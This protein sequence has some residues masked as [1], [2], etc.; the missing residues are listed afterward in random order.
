MLFGGPYRENS[1][2]EPKPRLMARFNAWLCSHGWHS[3]RVIRVM[4][5]GEGPDDSDALIECSR[6]GIRGWRWCGGKITW[7]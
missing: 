6:C 4:C 3:A 2:K 5:G 7:D 1:Y